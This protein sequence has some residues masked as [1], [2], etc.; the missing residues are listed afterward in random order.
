MGARA[1]HDG[2]N[3]ARHE[4][5]MPQSA[6][7]FQAPHSALGC[8]GLGAAR[9]QLEAVR[10]RPLQP[11]LDGGAIAAILADLV[12]WV[13]TVPQ[14]LKREHVRPVAG[15]RAWAFVVEMHPIAGPEPLELL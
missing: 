1:T 10:R 11:L 9:A 2:P 7:D 6:S 14:L 15:R 4:R 8:S 5:S 3:R 12:G 13:V